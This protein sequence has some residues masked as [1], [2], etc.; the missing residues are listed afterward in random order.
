MA[1]KRAMNLRVLRWLWMPGEESRLRTAGLDR[2]EWRRAS[3]IAHYMDIPDFIEAL[4][5]WS[6]RSN[7]GK[8]G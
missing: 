4:A 1:S 8:I 3:S 5:F 6:E 2:D 7:Y